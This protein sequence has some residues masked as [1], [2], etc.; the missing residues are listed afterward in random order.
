MIGDEQKGPFEIRQLAEEGVR[1]D[2]YVWCKTMSDWTPASQVPEIRRFFQSRIESQQ[3]I[4]AVR[5]QEQAVREEHEQEEL[6]RK[7][8]PM[9][10]NM[11]RKSGIKLKPEDVP[12]FKGDGPNPILPIILFILF[13]I[14]II[15]GFLIK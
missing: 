3:N 4:K 9:A 11:I 8:P 12:N 15:A 13:F 6:I 5:E 10:Q 7:F 2:T 14:L 1:P